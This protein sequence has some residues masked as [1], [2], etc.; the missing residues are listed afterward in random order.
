MPEPLDKEL[1]EKV[2]NAIYK[3][4]PKH[5]AYR[6]GLIVQE[7]KKQGG[8]Y[9]GTK[10]TTTGLK[11]WFN[12]KWRNQ[13]GDIGYAKKGDIY[14]PTIRVTDKT[15]TTIHELSKK[16]IKNAMKEKAK[17]GHVRRFDK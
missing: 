11:R 3:K 17:T 15:P 9:E 1:Y 2:K 5:S 7:Y 4:Y 14:R 8:T 12:E 6:S 10:P 16:Q 13:R